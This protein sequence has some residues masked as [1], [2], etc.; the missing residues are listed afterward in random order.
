MRIEFESLKEIKEFVLMVDIY[1]LCVKQEEW[2][3][4][5]YIITDKYF[6]SESKTEE[7][8]AEPRE[9]RII[10]R[11]GDWIILTPYSRQLSWLFAILSR[12]VEYNDVGVKRSF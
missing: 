4:L 1:H 12:F 6:D 11:N 10:K 9:S 2:G 3:G 5:G 8:I 7:R